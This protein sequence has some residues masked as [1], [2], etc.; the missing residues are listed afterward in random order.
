MIAAEREQFKTVSIQPIKFSSWPEI[1]EALKAGAIDGAFLLTPIGLTLRQKG[2]PIKVVLLGHRNGSVIT[3]KNSGEINR[4]EDLKGKTIAI[5]S[6]FSTH[7]I[8]LRKILTEKHI[9]PVHDLKII[10]MA[11]PE[12]LVA[13]A[14]GRIHGYIVAEPFGAQA[15]AQKVGKVL[16]LSKDIWPK[17]ICC[18]LNLREQVIAAHPEEVQELVGGMVRTAA[19]IEANPA[20]AAKGSVKLLG[21]KPEIIEKVLTTPRGRLTFLNLVPANRDFAAT[22]DYMVKFGIAKDKVNLAGY[23]DDRFARKIA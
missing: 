10:D 21:Q 16:M 8:L 14:T 19:F 6:P 13:L 3:V 20:Q 9:D 5:P 17:H 1:A 23:L 12:M 22:Q 4:I 15:E 7:N 11:P 18:V 2:V